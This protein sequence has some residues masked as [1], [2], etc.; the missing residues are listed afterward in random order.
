LRDSYIRFRKIIQNCVVTLSADA[1]D[2]F[3]LSALAVLAHCFKADKERK[4][5]NGL[6]CMVQAV[7]KLH[8]C[9]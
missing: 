8:L 7:E 2:I 3:P 5:C 6:R 9:N 4:Y 1:L